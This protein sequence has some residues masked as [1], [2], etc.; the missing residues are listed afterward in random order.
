MVKVYILDVPEFQ[1]IIEG[2]RRVGIEVGGPAKGYYV[3]SRE[4]EVV[5]SRK[6][7][8]LKPAV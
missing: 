7:L 4:G 5:F 1:P 3:I 2:A 8:G 6:A